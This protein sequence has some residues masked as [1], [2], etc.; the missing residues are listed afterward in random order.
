[1][2][3]LCRRSATELAALIAAR[4]VSSREVVEAHLARIDEVNGHVNAVTVVLGASA[5]AGR[6]RGGCRAR[7]ALGSGH[8][9]APR[10]SL[11]HI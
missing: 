1:M 10:L 3:E 6:R 8:W 11:I 4:D 9:S 7:G 5:L 2:E